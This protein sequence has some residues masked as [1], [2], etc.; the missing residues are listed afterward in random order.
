MNFMQFIAQELREYMARLGVRT[1]DELVGRTDLLKRK[2]N[3]TYSRAAR[4]DLSNILG[5]PYEGQKI[6]GY[7]EKQV[8]DFELEKTVDERVLMKKMKSAIS[9]RQKRS[10]SVDVTNVNRRLHRY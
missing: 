4:V 9:S 6:A 3:I 2:E 10:I 5:N 7:H 1:V 8:Y